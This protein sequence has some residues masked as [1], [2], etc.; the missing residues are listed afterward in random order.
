MR[1]TPVSYEVPKW[2]VIVG[3]VIVIAIIGGIYNAV[4]GGDSNPTPTTAATVRAGSPEV[5]SRI[6]GYTDCEDVQAEFD[7][8]QA[9]LGTAVSQDQ[10][11]WS[12]GYMAAATERMGELGC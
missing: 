7:Q 10:Q 11:D 12:L 8:A 2:L 6:A 4:T 9:N 3:V 5:Y 1:D